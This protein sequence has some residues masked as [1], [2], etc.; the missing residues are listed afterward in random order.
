MFFYASCFL[1]LPLTPSEFFNGMLAVSEPGALDCYTFFRPILS[2]L[3][4]SRESNVNSFSSFRIT[5]FSALRSDRT[6]SRSSILFPNATHPGSGV[7]IFVRKGLSSSEL[8]TSSLSSLDPYSDYVGVNISLN[9]S[10]S[11]SFLNPYWTATRTNRQNTKI[12]QYLCL[13]IPIN[14]SIKKF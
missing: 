2:T 12:F 13:F 11:L 9:N 7:I 10:S 5:G 14:M 1:F 3:S 4:V 8:S 6:Y